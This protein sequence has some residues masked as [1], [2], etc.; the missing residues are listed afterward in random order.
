MRRIGL[1]AGLCL[2]FVVGC[3]GNATEPDRPSG[4]GG[5]ARLFFYD[6][7]PNVAGA[8]GQVGR[9]NADR[10]FPSLYEAVQAAVRGK[11]KAERVD[12]PPD[13]I[14]PAI[15]RRFG[16]DRQ[17]ILRHYDRRN[18]TAGAKYYLFAGGEG[19][20]RRL[21]EGPASSCAELLSGQAEFPGKF[22]P[23][24]QPGPTEDECR[25]AARKVPSA[26]PR[27]APQL[28]EV[29]AGMV[30]LQAERARGAPATAQINQYYALEDDAELSARDIRN[31][32]ANTE[33]QTHEPIVTFAFTAQGRKAFAR[34]TKRLAERGANVIL[35]RGAPPSVAYQSFAIALDNRIVS[36]AS[37]DFRENPDG[38]DPR[39]GAQI[40]GIGN[41][42]ETQTVAERLR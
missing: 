25:A 34:L 6:W 39:A 16:G 41:L 42:E 33:P 3:G 2:S 30:V 31:P 12:I 21:L 14:E 20:D 8:G 18:D 15:E 10:P 35:P 9:G 7:E 5:K 32:E 23:P 19:P 38:I 24:T 37:I 1:I 11:P 29:P 22:D 28:V 27:R 4:R 17:R 13:G 26:R 36:H 40:V